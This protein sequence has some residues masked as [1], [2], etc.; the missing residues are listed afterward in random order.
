MYKWVNF[1]IKIC[2]S[3]EN[4]LCNKKFPNYMTLSTYVMN[5]AKNELYNIELVLSRLQYYHCSNKIF[6]IYHG[7]LNYSVG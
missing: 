6:N 7:Y 4:L 1:S 3:G 2:R 5:F